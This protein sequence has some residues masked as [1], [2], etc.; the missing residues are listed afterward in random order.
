VKLNKPVLI[1]IAGPN[2]SGKTSVT[3]QI[4]KHEWVENC[5]YINPDN[6]AQEK[7]GDWNSKDAVLKAAQLSTEIREN[8]LKNSESFIFETVFS[9]IDKVDFLQKAKDAGF[10]IRLFFVGTNS[11]T[12]N[13]S[14]IAQRVMEGGHDVPISKIINRYYKSINNACLAAPFVDRLYVYDNSKNLAPAKLLF[15]A[16]NGK[17]KKVYSKVND[18]AESIKLSV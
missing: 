14:R 3:S 13:A 11:P 7:F 10:F 2:G 16:D 9:I 18:W 4:L 8:C 5:I 17:L 6:I 15:R 12:I 1:V